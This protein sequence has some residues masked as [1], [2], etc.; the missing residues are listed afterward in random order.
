MSTETNRHLS[1]IK[2]YVRA[3]NTSL[4]E[5]PNPSTVEITNDCTKPVPV[6]FCDPQKE[7]DKTILCDKNTFAKVVVVTEYSSTGVPTSTAYN[8]DGS[9]Y[10]GDIVNDLTLCEVDLESDD[11]IICAN[12]VG[13]VQWVVKKNGVPTGEIYYTDKFGVLVSTPADFTYG[14]C[15]LCL[16]L[17]EGFMGD[18]A[19]LA[20]FDSIYID[21]PKCC[22]VTYTT[23]AGTVTLPAKEQN[24]IFT[25]SFNCF[26]SSYKISATCDVNLIFSLLTKTK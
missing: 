24:W 21:I 22:S 15:Q 2:G 10:T 13:L 9:L 20:E 14:E 3:I 19:T 5:A 6:F 17:Q 7:F 23:S 18:A 12:G 11:I 4:C 8:L 1:D 25:Q 26:V 16:P